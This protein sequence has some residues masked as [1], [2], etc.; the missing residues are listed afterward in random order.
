[1]RLNVPGTAIDWP[2]RFR[3]LSKTSQYPAIM[4]YY[5]TAIPSLTTPLSEVR[6]MAMDFETTGLD[7]HND[8]IISIGVVPFDLNRVYLNQAKHWTLKPHQKIGDESVVIHGI[9]HS[10]VRQAPD[11]GV[12]MDELIQTMSG[13]IMVVHYRFIERAF[14]SKELEL[15][16]K[17]GLEFP[18]LDTLELEA[19]I[20]HAETGG[21]WNRLKGK[22]RQSIR[23]GKSRTRYG[24]PA[25]TPHHALIDAIATAELLQAQIAHHFDSE[26]PVSDLWL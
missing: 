14:L 10:D 1:M 13:H 24:L 7:P 4:D 26:Q 16:V 20:Q 12:I 18:L 21:L 15:R 2:A 19:L 5:Q 25:Y 22:K 3:A 17:D 6:F 23:L 9:T 8:E 11:F